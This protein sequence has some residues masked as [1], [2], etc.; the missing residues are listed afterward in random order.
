[1]HCGLMRNAR[2]VADTTN[3][4]V[5]YSSGGGKGGKPG[6]WEC[7]SCRILNFASRVRCFKCDLEKPRDAVTIA[8]RDD[9]RRGGGGGRRNDSRDRGG[10]GGYRGGDRGGGG[11]RRS[12][13]SRS[14]DRR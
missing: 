7:D 13:R 6:D 1:M 4:T 12:S 11:G 5:T 14:R 8:P 2:V 9:D 3:D 10:K